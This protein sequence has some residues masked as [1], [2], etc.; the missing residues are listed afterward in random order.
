ME[1]KIIYTEQSH[2]DMDNIWDYIASDLQ[3]PESAE[4]MLDR[5]MDTVDQLKLFP[6]SSTMLSAVSGANINEDERFLVCGKYL[7]FYKAFENEVYIDRVLYG[8]RDYLRVLF[9]ES[10]EEE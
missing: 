2:R 8:G 4:K 6:E 1:N 9:E 10:F 7:I 5:I 3:N